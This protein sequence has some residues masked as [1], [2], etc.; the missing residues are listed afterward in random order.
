MRRLAIMLAMVMLAMPAAGRGAETR[1]TTIP[2]AAT[3]AYIVA[4]AF[5]VPKEAAPDGEGY[6]ALVE[7]R[8]GRLYIGT[9]VE[10]GSSRLVEFDPKE[11]RMRI[12][13]DTHKEL[14]TNAVGYAAQS[15]IHT[16]G[17]VGPS[18]RIYFGTKQ[19][20]VPPDRM[21]NYPGGYPMVY[22]PSTGKT[23]VYPILVAH[24]GIASITPDESRGLAY[25]S[26]C[27]DARPVESARFVIL[28]LETGKSRVL[29]DCRHSYAFVV[30]D[31]LGR[32]YHPILGGDI[33]R[34]DPRSDKLE[35]L[36]QTI[37]GRPPLPESRLADPE[38]SVVNW[39]IS[40]DGKTLYAVPM[41]ANRLYAYDLT[42]AGNA[43]PGRNLGRLLAPESSRAVGNTNAVSKEPVTDCRALCVG[44]S[45]TVWASITE[46]RM[47]GAGHHLASYRP[48][49]AAPFDHGLVVIGNPDYTEVLKDRP[50]QELPPQF[51]NGLLRRPDG[52]MTTRYV[53]LGVCAARDGYVYVLTL[54]PYTL[55]QLAPNWNTTRNAVFAQ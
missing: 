48:G 22:D 17:N 24:E 10:G 11:K 12:V 7:G 43:I 39:D 31:Y 45:G 51:V 4:T 27:S 55:L 53:T 15:K 21:T 28:N 23:R 5:A 2:P 46:S 30:V 54:Q 18:G 20:H 50:D 32:A 41:Q 42:A 9:L 35:R 16:R 36:K 19:G 29:M 3:G 1:A 33:A 34:Y 49:A 8:N 52:V 40:P 26:T 37:D 38:G 13:V 6:F 44:P 14:G 47:E 25:V